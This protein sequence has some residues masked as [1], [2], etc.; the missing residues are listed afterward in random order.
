MKIPLFET[1][2]ALPLRLGNLDYCGAMFFPDERLGVQMR[3]SSDNGTKGDI[4]LYNLRLENIPDDLHAPEV[5]EFFQTACAD[6]LGQAER[7]LLLDLE[8]KASQ[9]LPID[10]EEPSYLWAVFQYRQAPGPGTSYEGE[11]FSH[12]ALR[13]DGGYINK[14]RYTYPAAIAEESS[15]GLMQFLYEWRETVACFLNPE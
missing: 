15:L 3:Y 2:D 6:V 5:M 11:R 1:D 4:Y 13:T 12:L 8:I 7:G 9:Y 10:S 14:V